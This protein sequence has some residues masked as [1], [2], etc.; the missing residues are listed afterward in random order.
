MKFYHRTKELAWEKIKKEGILFG[1]P[2]NHSYRYTYLSPLDFGDS[3][4]PILL[5]VDYEPRGKPFDNYGFNPPEGQI[6][7]QFSV[8]VPIDIKKVKL[9]KK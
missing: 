4:G 5:E 6:C 2:D 7:W 1:I 3:Y 9:I 8:F